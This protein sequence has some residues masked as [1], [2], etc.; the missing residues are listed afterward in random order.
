MTA[1]VITASCIYFISSGNLFL[2]Q[3]EKENHQE[4][5]LLRQLYEDVK[6]FRLLQ[7]SPVRN[8]KWQEG[9]TVIEHHGENIQKAQIS[10]GEEVIEIARK[11]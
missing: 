3:R 9:E 1:L 4:V 7:E 5:L 11:N 6:H 10:N 2:I 8:E